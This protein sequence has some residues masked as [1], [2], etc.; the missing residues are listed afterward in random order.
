MK[1][2]F[3]TV[4]I[5]LGNLFISFLVNCLPSAAKN[6]ES[7]GCKAALSKSK[8]RIERAK[9]KVTHISRYKHQYTNGPE[10]KN[11]TYTFTMSGPGTHNIISS[12]KILTA[13]SKEIILS[14]QTVGSVSFGVD[15]TDEGY[16]YGLMNNGAIKEFK[17]IE[18]KPDDQM[19]IHWG[20]QI[21][22]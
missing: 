1:Q 3:L 21:C 4:T 13:I 19:S 17:C 5:L 22:L 16:T 10:R 6:D 2:R 15:R 11:F 12:R 8:N 18:P 20:E 14:C 9:T 7:P